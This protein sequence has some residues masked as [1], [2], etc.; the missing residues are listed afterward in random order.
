MYVLTEDS[1]LIPFTTDIL[2]ASTASPVPTVNMT[3][4]TSAPSSF[5]SL[6]KVSSSSASTSSGSVIK[7]SSN[8]L[9]Q[10]N[11]VNNLHA[12]TPIASTSMNSTINESSSACRRI[13]F[14]NFDRSPFKQYLKVKDNYNPTKKTTKTRTKTPAAISGNEYFNSMIRNQEE[15]ERILHEKEERKR[16]RE[17]KKKEN[18]KGKGKGRS[19]K[20]ETI[21]SDSSSE[22]DGLAENFCSA[23]KGT[24]GLNDGSRWIGCNTCHRWYH[25]DCSSEDFEDMT[26]IEIQGVNFICKY[27]TEK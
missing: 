21:A 5:N 6:Q 15:K 14:E 22:D 10:G 19:K 20:K 25:K 8:S 4:S 3:I 26:D 7:A 18:V 24:D 1:Q 9:P 23:C 11:S 27:C 2:P 16:A 12:C 17:E 13:S